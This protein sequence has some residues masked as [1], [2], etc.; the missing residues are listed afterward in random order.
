MKFS[1]P[2]IIL[3]FNDPEHVYDKEHYSYLSASRGLSRPAFK[4]G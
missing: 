4:A 2:K 1:I 3:L